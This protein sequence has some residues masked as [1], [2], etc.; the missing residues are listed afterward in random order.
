MTPDLPLR[1][2]SHAAAAPVPGSTGRSPAPR[3]R[4]P[5]S[6]DYAANDSG[7]R[8]LAMRDADIV[9]AIAKNE[10]DGLSAA[11]R[12]YA[13]RLYDY[14]LRMLDDAEA[15][16]DT[17]HDVF[18]IAR[19]RITQLRNPDALRPWLYAIARSQCHRV[20]RS[21]H[22]YASLDE[23]AELSD[24]TLGPPEA[25]VH[26]EETRL[27][28]HEAM[29]GLNPRE[30][31]VIHLTLRHQ[32]D[33]PGLAAV[34]GVS[35]RQANA[36]A[37]T[38]RAQLERSI[39]ALLVA[40]ARG[41]E[42]A[43]L[44]TL[45]RDWD[46]RLSPLWRKRINRHL[47]TCENCAR[48]RAALVAPASLLSLLP[49]AAAPAFLHD[50]LLA[51]AFDPE[52]VAHHAEFADRAGPYRADGF[53]KRSDGDAAGSPGSRPRLSTAVT[54][55]AALLALAVA[56]WAALP[57]LSEVVARGNEVDAAPVV[58]LEPVAPRPSG[59]APQG[60]AGT[61]T[62]PADAPSPGGTGTAAP[63]PTPSGPADTPEAEQPDADGSEPSTA[64]LAL[65]A[66][67][68]DVT[69]EECPPVWTLAVT[70][71]VQGEATAV[72]LD[73]TG[74]SGTQQTA[75]SP[76][77][78][79]GEW[80]ASVSGLPPDTSVAWTVTAGAADGSTAVSSG[81]AYRAGCGETPG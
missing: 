33:G 15:A 45:L 64:P 62:P 7:A 72:T 57:L 61:G 67:A 76:G 59:S 53:P 54:L 41:R 31:E 1:R 55:A 18:L 40:R 50:Q 47:A 5:D 71:R 49:V 14:S 74:P 26:R 37:A 6:R 60:T 11:Y 66:H 34:L 2:T 42:C 43:A 39:G 44:R 69:A 73:V 3:R 80:Y 9:H 38:A 27:L 30:R 48:E 51:N 78:T 8:L 75:M 20:L 12:A 10:R 52:L 22:R 21:R 23:A 63:S 81:K 77:N 35:V 70:A 56:G 17:V 29:S 28:V 16:A 24:E 4:R 36:V 13:D 32:L 25:G 65:S 68:Q 46:G 58:S 79:P 19:E